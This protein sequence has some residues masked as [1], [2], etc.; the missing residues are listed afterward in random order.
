MDLIVKSYDQKTVFLHEYLM[1]D[2]F[3]LSVEHSRKVLELS[4]NF[5]YNSKKILAPEA[6]RSSPEAPEA[7]RSL[8]DPPGALSQAALRRRVRGC[9]LPRAHLYQV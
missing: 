7:P 4:M 3:H 8:T 2:Y 1:H 6:P 5:Q 9:C